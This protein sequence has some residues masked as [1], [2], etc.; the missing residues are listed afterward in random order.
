MA[1]KHVI[2]HANTGCT[3]DCKDCGHKN[4]EVILLALGSRVRCAKCDNGFVVNV[5]YESSKVLLTEF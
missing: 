2:A 3:W 1:E 5:L 4:E